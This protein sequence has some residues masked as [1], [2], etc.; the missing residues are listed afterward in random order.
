MF[1]VEANPQKNRLYVTLEGH[2]DA[3]ERNR[4]MEEFL[5]KVRELKPGFDV[6][7]D[8]SRLHPTDDEGLHDL[9]RVQAALKVKGLRAVVRIVKIPLVRLQFERAARENGWAFETVET[10]A[11]AEAKLIRPFSRSKS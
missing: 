2:L 10:L 3:T 8:M 5:S 1:K 6:V 11:E 9:I 4:V 7:H